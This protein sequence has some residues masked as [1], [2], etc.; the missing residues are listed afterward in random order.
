MTER[1]AETTHV[2]DTAAHVALRRSALTGR[3]SASRTVIRSI[4]E[5]TA[6]G[7]TVGPAASTRSAWKGSANASHNVPGKSVVKMG[8]A[9]VVETAKKNTS[10][11]LGIV[12]WPVRHATTETRS[13]GTVVL[14]VR[15]RNFR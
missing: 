9:A 13:T 8:A 10:A 7:A 5:V 3:A 1:S 11:L 14:P 6:A 4:A 15:L 2:V 12:S